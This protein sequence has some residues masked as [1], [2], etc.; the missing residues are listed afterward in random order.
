MSLQ[1]FFFFEGYYDISLHYGLI[2]QKI[3]PCDKTAALIALTYA[4]LGQGERSLHCAREALRIY[5]D[6][7]FCLNA[8]AEI[9]SLNGIPIE[10]PLSQLATETLNAAVM[11]YIRN[12]RL[13]LANRYLSWLFENRLMHIDVFIDAIAVHPGSVCPK[14]VANV[15]AIVGEDAKLDSLK[16][17]MLGR[18]FEKMKDVDRAASNYI[19]ANKIAYSAN[20]IKFKYF[21]L[22]A[23]YESMKKSF[24]YKDYNNKNN[25]YDN[26]RTAAVTAIP[27]SGMSV[28]VNFLNRSSEYPPKNHAGFGEGLRSKSDFRQISLEAYSI[29]S[30]LL[31]LR[32]DLSYHIGGCSIKFCGTTDVNRISSSGAVQSIINIIRADAEVVADMYLCPNINKLSIFFGIDSSKLYVDLM[33]E[34]VSVIES[35]SNLEIVDVSFDH[36][37][38]DIE[39]FFDIYVPAVSKI[40]LNT[41]IRETLGDRAG[42]SFKNP[43]NV[44]LDS[45]SR[46]VRLNI[47]EK[48]GSSCMIA[49]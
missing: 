40:Q 16:Y 4:R 48:I 46:S 44:T 37:C 25:I 38:E 31:K 27:F 10:T 41:K 15:E 26:Y 20:K 22:K 23:F 49:S 18:L 45:E 33:R 2:E 3:S 36:I 9:S 14:W 32:R 12:N 35:K 34:W 30:P 11:E 7:E 19:Y 24:L 6:S 47:F 17:F 13:D 42:R 5:P 21:E 28:L 8:F 39:S 43:Y 29:E 1:E